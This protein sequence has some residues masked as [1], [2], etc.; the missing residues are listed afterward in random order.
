VL[1]LDDRV[2]HLGVIDLADD[3]ESMILGHGGDSGRS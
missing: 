3:V 1:G 2:V